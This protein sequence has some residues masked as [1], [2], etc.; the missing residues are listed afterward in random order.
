VPQPFLGA[1]LQS[2]PLVRNREALSS[3]TAAMSFSTEVQKRTARRLVAA[4]FP[5][6]RATRSCLVPPAT[7]RSLSP[8]E[9]GSRSLWATNGRAAHS[10]S[11]VD[12]AASFSDESV[13]SQPVSRLRGRCSPGLPP[14]RRRPLEPGSL[15]PDR[16]E[17]RPPLT[18]P[19]PKASSPPASDA[20]DR[21]PPRQVNS[22]RRRSAGLVRRQL[23][24]PFEIGPHCLSTA[25]PPALTFLVPANRNAW[26]PRAHS[27]RRAPSLKR[28]DRLPGFPASS[29]ASQL[30]VRPRS[31]S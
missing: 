12:S 7:M 30:Q 3:P 4:R 6:A 28:P 9:A 22:L 29:N 11:F 10:P 27:P 24:I 23:P 14:R 31:G 13:R 1:L 19:D 17:G 21:D 8:A 2:V 16:P 26:P 18:T 20:R 15:R 25:T 5:D